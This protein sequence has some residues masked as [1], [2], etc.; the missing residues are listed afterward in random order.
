MRD[1]NKLDTIGKRINFIRS[2]LQV[3]RAYLQHKYN[4][5]ASS[6]KV[7]E[8]DKIVPSK[9]SIETLIYA[10]NNEGIDVS[11]EWLEEGGDNIP[12]LPQLS[13]TND[14]PE[15]NN[16]DLELISSDDHRALIEIK[17]ITSLYS[18]CIY[19]YLSD[20]SMNPRYVANT[21]LIGRK[22]LLSESFGHDCIIKFVD[23]ETLT[24]RRL[25]KNKKDLCTLFVLNPI[26]G[27]YD[28]NITCPF[29]QIESVAPVTWTRNLF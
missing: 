23:S 28:P 16:K 8:H 25:I 13:V 4:I 18:D 5:S 26:N 3:T 22:K 1:N 9:T 17:K 11:T 21:W 24:F 12:N 7:W 15:D 27:I 14:I 2:I 6:L 10:Y 20:D 19:M 29:S